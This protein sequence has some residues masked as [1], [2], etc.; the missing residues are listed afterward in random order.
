MQDS[1]R[2]AAGLQDQAQRLARKGFAIVPVS[3][4]VDGVCTCRQKARCNKAAKHPLI[5]SWQLKSSTAS[6][7]IEKWWRKWPTANIGVVT[8]K[9]SGVVVLDFDPRHGGDETLENLLVEFSGEL[10]GTYHV[11]TGGGGWH[12][13][14]TEPFGG[15]PSRANIQPGLDTRG[16]GGLIVAAGSIHASG[17][18]YV[19]ADDDLEPLELSAALFQ[20]IQAWTQKGHKESHR[21]HA[22]DTQEKHKQGG[23]VANGKTISDNSP[24]TTKLD[25]GSLT[26]DQRTAIT[27]AVRRS[28]PQHGGTR[29]KKLFELCRRLQAVKGIDWPTIDVRELRGL[30]RKWFDMMQKTAQEKRF[31]VEGTFPDCW[32]D[33][34][35]GW[36]RVKMPYNAVLE[37]C[38]A[39]VRQSLSSG[40]FP[41]PVSQCID[42]LGYWD[43][44]P[45]V[46][47]ILLCWF[48]DQHAAA[49]E[50]SFYL[51]CR[52]GEKTLAA[53]GTPMKSF[54]EVSRRMKH[55][56]RDG[57]V[58]C[59][60]R[61][62]PGNRGSAS[63]YRWSFK[64][65]A[66]PTDN[67]DWIT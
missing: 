34:A 4:A 3:A 37:E 53:I 24:A 67:L 14:F 2:P 33:F 56:E 55:L 5:K 25:F 52:I 50:E 13:Y 35:Y 45:T 19:A 59:V 6:D 46:A 57:V 1:T 44:T 26:K 9:P 61:S 7:Q 62:K 21:S 31:V 29:N 11:K 17:Q 47:L 63:E 49:N 38:V 65:P 8:G 54:Q 66:T 40:E 16:D 39:G 12:F 10:W 43:D 42:A 22:G 15:L 58:E 23:H 27:N 18:L 30:V 60:V 41:L 64:P 36:P 32:N 28:I 20:Q 51:S 48:L